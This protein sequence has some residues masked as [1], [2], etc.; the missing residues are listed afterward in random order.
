M[1][2][3]SSAGWLGVLLAAG[4]LAWMGCR[5]TP[6]PP[7]ELPATMPK[8]APAA[9]P[10]AES[11]APPLTQPTAPVASR[12]AAAE[13]PRP[14]LPKPQYEDVPPYR[15]VITVGSP[16]DPQAG[17]LH[18]ESLADDKREAAVNGLFPEANRI[19]VD[20]NNVAELSLDLSML[21]IRPKRRIILS[22]D[23]EGIEL[24]QRHKG[25][26]RLSRSPTG[27]WTVTTPIP[28]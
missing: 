3:R 26:I 15:V 10:E 6:K 22:I 28:Q 4:A 5:E 24:S 17:W 2:R 1:S 18:I 8:T 21:P 7:P 19:R 14:K 25:K 16:D 12:P 11:V 20:T 13:V 9:P 27:H 23:N